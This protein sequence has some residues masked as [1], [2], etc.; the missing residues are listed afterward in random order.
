MVDRHAAGQ[1]AHAGIAGGV[2]RHDTDGLHALGLDL[3]GNHRGRLAGL[4]MLAAG[5]RDRVIVED[6]VGHVRAGGHRSA[7]RETAGVRI[8]A[9]AEIDEHMVLVGRP[10]L[11]DPADAFAAHLARHVGL[12][13]RHEVRHV[14]AAD[15]GQRAAAFRHHGGG[16]VRTAGTEVRRAHGRRGIGAGRLRGAA[17]AVEIGRRARGVP[18]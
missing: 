3:L 18:A 12:P 13:V 4:H 5:H 6:L 11:A 10:V 2:F 1:V 15:A 7:D 9:V 17:D 16:I 14:M 8:G